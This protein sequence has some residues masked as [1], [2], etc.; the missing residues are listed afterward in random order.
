MPQQA[1]IAT[2]LDRVMAPTQSLAGQLRVKRSE[3]MVSELEA[4]A[5]RVFEQRGFDVTVEEIAAEAQI[6]VRTF[7]R[8]FPAKDDVLQV[9]IDRRSAALRDALAA[10]PADEPPMHSLRVALEEVV[11][12]E[13]PELLRRWTTVVAA[14]PNALRGV[15]GGIQMKGHQVIAEFFATRLGGTSDALM[16]TMLAA[17]VGGVI[18]AAQTQWF[19]RGG[20]LG[21][22]IYQG[23]ALLERGIGT[24][25]STSPTRSRKPKPGSAPAAARRKL[26]VPRPGA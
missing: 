1:D 20:D 15:L 3:M 11:S 10:R 6:S 12:A 13:D 2:T 8:Y 14:T 25:P 23:L 22:A 4:V 18:Q 17:A 5:L 26:R 9:R 7:Y 24:D 21:A 19:F 16:P